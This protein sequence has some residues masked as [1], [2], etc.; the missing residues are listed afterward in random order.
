MVNAFI[1]STLV[2]AADPF[3][4]KPNDSLPG[5]QTLVE[6]VGGLMQWGI[7]LA[8]G[9]I[10]IGVL[11]AVVGKAGHNSSHQS[12]GKTMALVAVFA[13]LVIG[14]ANTI[15]KTFYDMGEKVQAGSSDSGGGDSSS[16]SGSKEK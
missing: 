14:G 4:A 3:S 8:V 12:S 1:Q 5:G 7:V 16:R 10:I 13:L 6:L 2:A 9:G 11:L 15:G